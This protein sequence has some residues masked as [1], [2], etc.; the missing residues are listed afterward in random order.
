MDHSSI[1]LAYSAYPAV[2][3]A[4]AP[5][6]RFSL[7]KEFRDG[8]IRL[9]LRKEFR[10]AELGGDASENGDF[11]SEKQRLQGTNFSRSFHFIFLIKIGGRCDRKCQFSKRETALAGCKNLKLNFDELKHLTIE[12][13]I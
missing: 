1:L 7:H 10:A 6:I 3:P 9:Y 12:N 2:L 5:R 13:L 11:Q 4:L 8:E